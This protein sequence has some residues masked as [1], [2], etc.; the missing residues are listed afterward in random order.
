MSR[1][2]QTL[3]APEQFQKLEGAIQDPSSIDVITRKPQLLVRDREPIKGSK[4]T[5]PSP[6]T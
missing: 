2:T 3:Q 6:R 5:S 4:S 1:P